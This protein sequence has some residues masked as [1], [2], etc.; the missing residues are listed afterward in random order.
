MLKVKLNSLSRTAMEDFLL[1][2][3]EFHEKY[4]TLGQIRQ[5]NRQ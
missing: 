4:I 1:K 2:D 3:I 5:S